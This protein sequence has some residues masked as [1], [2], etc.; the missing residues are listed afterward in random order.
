MFCS[1]LVRATLWYVYYM[2]EAIQAVEG[3]HSV[4]LYSGW[5][6]ANSLIQE[7]MFYKFK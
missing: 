2:S 6:C 1:I 4:Y 5:R 3:T 7:L